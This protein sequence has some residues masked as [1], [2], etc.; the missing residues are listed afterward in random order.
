[1]KSSQC[2]LGNGRSQPPR[3]NVVATEA[4]TIMF[5]YSARKYNDQRKPLNS[6]MYPATSSDSASGK[7]NGA[8]LVSAIEATKY[9]KNATGASNP[10]QMPWLRWA[11]TIEV[12][13]KVPA[14]SSPHT[15]AIPAAVS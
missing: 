13:F 5:V 14:K 2:V 4:T 10:N 6:V 1:M 7:S 12:M 3:N 8:R 9:V 11:S 15:S